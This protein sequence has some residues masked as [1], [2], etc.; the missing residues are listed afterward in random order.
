MKLT[1]RYHE[2]K[3]IYT[4]FYFLIH[5]LSAEEN[6]YFQRFSTENGLA[7]NTVYCILQD[8]QGFMWFGTK[9]GLCR[10]DGYQFKTFR[11]E[12]TP[13]SIGNS[14]IRSLHQ[15]V[16]GLIWAG[17]DRGIYIY[18]PLTESFIHFDQQTEQGISIEKEVNDIQQNKEG[19][20]WFAVDWQG[21][22]QFHTQEQKLYF[23]DLNTIVN[24]WSIYIDPENKVWTGTHGG[25]LNYFNR[26]T[27]KFETIT[28]TQEKYNA[29]G[30][31]YRVYENTYNSI[32]IGTATG[33]KRFDL[34]TNQMSDFLTTDKDN[35]LFV[36]DILRR[37]ENKIWFGTEAG[38]Y[39][40]N[41]KTNA[42]QHLAHDYTDDLSIAD[43]AIY[44]IY[45]DQEGGIWV[46]TYFGGVNYYPTQYTP[47]EKY[48]P[49]AGN[50]LKGKRVREIR[51]DSNNKIWIG[52]EDEGL[53]I[54][55]P[56][57]HRFTHM[58]SDGSPGT[59]SYYNIHGIMADGDNV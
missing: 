4:N 15:D 16:N 39:I 46:G 44:C 36:R 38:I 47:F 3:F 18:N 53:T 50:S 22:F 17:T 48:Y 25:G 55:D 52:T 35:V 27:N 30:D 26:E 56:V 32:L 29:L 37:S 59:I 19:N 40:Y 23:Y 11:N 12:Q 2:K 41:E 24:A 33:V 28:Y 1:V 21:V 7:Q 14:F 58:R 51:Q 5:T 6:F 10:Y 20:L 43:N 45:K 54:F 9:D 13:G 8:Q 49:T 42:I 57:Q 34:V 31:I